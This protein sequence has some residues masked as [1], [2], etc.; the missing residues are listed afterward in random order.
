MRVIMALTDNRIIASHLTLFTAPVDTALPED[1]TQF[2]VTAETVDTTWSNFGHT[3]DDDRIAFEKDDGD[4]TT[5]ATAIRDNDRVIYQPGTVTVTGKLVQTDIVALKAIYNGW[6]FKKGMAIP[7][8]PKANEVAAFFLIQ[9]A[10]GERAGVY[11]PRLSIV[12]D[13]APDF[14]N[15]D[16]FATFGFK[17][18]AL[19]SN[20]LKSSTGESASWA[21]FTNAAFTKAA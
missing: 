17:G 2:N 16:N 4:T 3:S 8:T 7:D 14:S 20:V 10:N 12:P 11:M 6:D 5:L 18:T 1:L 13:G 15:K 9:D 21:V 19:T